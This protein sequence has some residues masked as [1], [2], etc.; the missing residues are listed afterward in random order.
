MNLVGR[1]YGQPK[2]VLH[3]GI[4][5]G[6]FNSKYNGAG[7]VFSAWERYLGNT[8]EL[9]NLMLRRMQKDFDSLA[10]R[11]RKPFGQAQLDPLFN[12]EF[13]LSPTFQRSGSNR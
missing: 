11:M 12:S 8:Q 3:D 2:F 5:A 4:S 10:P 9:V 1:I 7:T 13:S 6:L